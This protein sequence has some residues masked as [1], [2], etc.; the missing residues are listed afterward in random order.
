MTG[1]WRLEDEVVT[2]AL[3]GM[4]RLEELDLTEN[5]SLGGPSFAAIATLPALTKL[6]LTATEFSIAH[7]E[8]TLP[9]MLALQELDVSNCPIGINLWDTLPAAMTILIANNTAIF[10]G[11][12]AV[13]TTAKRL[14]ELYAQSPSCR[15]RSMSWAALTLSFGELRVLQLGGWEIADCGVNDALRTMPQLEVLD[16]PSCFLTGDETAFAVTSHQALRNVDLSYTSVGLTGMH[17][18]QGWTNLSRVGYRRANVE[19]CVE[20][21][22]QQLAG[23]GSTSESIDAS[24]RAWKRA[25]SV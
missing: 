21:T 4:P 5:R 1:S 2:E 3:S 7:A 8:R 25:R 24:P 6:V 16:L 13:R 17:A 14:R 19:G 11:D 18:L 15:E 23:T 20:E 22:G 9:Q 12:I 10:D